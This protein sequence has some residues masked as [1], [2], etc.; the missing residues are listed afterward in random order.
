MS[1]VWGVSWTEGAW[2]VSW[3]ATSPPP[4]PAP[5][6][7]PEPNAPAGSGGGGSVLARRRI[8]DDDDNLFLQEG[9][10]RLRRDDL[11]LLQVV[12]LFMEKIHE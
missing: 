4:P 5:V 7:Q 8:D 9:L 2:G 6:P 1:G 12:K 3:G 10:D 11:I